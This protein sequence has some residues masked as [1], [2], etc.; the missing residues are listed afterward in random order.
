M[1]SFPETYNDPGIFPWSYDLDMLVEFCVIP[2]YFIISEFSLKLLFLLEMSMNT[3]DAK[4]QRGRDLF[5]G[6]V[7]L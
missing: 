4:I 6:N 2:C 5:L 3:R 7:L 1:G